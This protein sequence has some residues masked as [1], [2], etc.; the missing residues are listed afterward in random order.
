[1]RH[2]AI[3]LRLATAF[4]LLAVVLLV[5]GWQ[6]ISHLRM[7]NAQMQ[8]IVYDP[9]AEEVLSYQAYRLSSQN[10]QITLLI[11]LVDDPDE[12]Q[13]LLAQR[14]ANSLRI[15]ELMVT[16]SPHVDNEDEKQLFANVEATRKPYVESYQRAIALLLTEHQRDSARK[17]MV[18]IVHPNLI[19]YH[20]AWGAFNQYEVDETNRDVQQSKDDFVAG[21]RNFLLMLAVAGLIT[22]AT[23]IFTVRQMSREIA[24]RQEVEQTMLLERSELDARVAERTAELAKVN[25][26]LQMENA[27]R[28]KIEDSLRESEIRFRGFFEQAAVGVAEVAPDGQFLLANQ[29]FA[30]IVGR[31][32]E[33]LQSCTFQEITHPDDLSKSQ[34]GVRGLLTGEAKAYSITKRYLHKNGDPVWV[35]LT[36]SLI[37]ECASQ[38]KHFLAVVEDITERKRL[39]SQLF[40]S[41]KL[42]TVGKLAG[43]IAHEFNSIMT[44]IIGY[45]ELMLSDLSS[46]NPIYKNATEIRHSAERAAALTRQLLAYGRKQSLQPE[47]LDLNSVLASMKDTLH[48]L[49]GQG[50]NLLLISA[51][52]LKTVKADAGQFQQVVMNLA[53]NAAEAMPHGGKLTLETANVTLEQEDVRSIPELKA[54]DYVMVAVTD[55]GTGISEK[56]RARLFEPFFTTKEVGSGVGLGLSTCYG[57]I[58]QSGGHISVH[59]EL[60]RGTVFKIYLPQVEQLTKAPV[61]RSTLTDLPH[62][63]ETILLVEDDPDLREMAATLLKRLGYTVLVAANGIEAL[64]IKQERKVEHIDLLFTDVVMPQMS[65]K[66]LSERFLALSPHTRILFTSAYTANAVVHQGGLNNGVALLQ[67]PFTPSA[68]AHK[69]REILDAKHLVSQ[70]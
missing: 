17:M 7:L 46:T 6:G 35:N 70:P 54:S 13:R 20:N 45:S 25:Q 50:T 62:G 56:V 49:L 58:K 27:E 22:G 68:L 4:C 43:G 52:D 24:V 29:R 44:A 61:P 19:A 8:K 28:K 31:T 26:E 41:Q 63:K 51:P 5:V 14:A 40:Q 37:A 32:R 12:I 15:T 11:F 66:E 48:H 34:T 23:A 38:P 9:W 30:D 36:V 60:G 33:E 21:Q 47:I 69:L 64:N 42:E 55:T 16:I 10:S 39:E 57:I 53:M 59:S 2:S 1:M 18:D 67:K 3:T 65:G